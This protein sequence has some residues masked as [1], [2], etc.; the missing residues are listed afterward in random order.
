MYL[1]SVLEGGRSWNSSV[2]IAI[3]AG[4]E[5]NYFEVM[6]DAAVI[7]NVSDLPTVIF[8][9]LQNEHAR[10]ITIEVYKYFSR[11]TPALPTMKCMLLN[12]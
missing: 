12:Y 4:M 7:L 5:K 10:E 1:V 8:H 9:R 2:Y 11:V 3:A 6:K